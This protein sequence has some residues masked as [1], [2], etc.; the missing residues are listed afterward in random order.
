M[1]LSEK[2]DNIELK[3]RQL[4]LKLERFRKENAD[5]TQKNEQLKAELDKQ[6]G[7]VSALKDKLTKTQGVL[8]R[9]EVNESE[10]SQQL[11]QQ[12]DQYI[13]EI[14]KCIEWLQNS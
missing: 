2:I 14:D 13:R 6:K 9:Q 11:K 1:N 3:I 12:L 10:H 5:L 8:E 7:T 4:A